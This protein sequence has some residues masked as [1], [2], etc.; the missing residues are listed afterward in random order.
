MK[1]KEAL[2]SEVISLRESKIVEGEKLCK[3]LLNTIL[4]LKGNIVFCRVRPLLSND[5]VKNDAKVA[6]F[7]T[8]TG[9]LGQGIDLTQNGQK[10]SFTLIKCSCLMPLRKM[11]M[12]RSHS[13]FRAY[14][15]DGYKVC[16]FAYGQTGSGKTHTMMDKPGLPDQK[17]LIPRSL[18]Q[19]FETRQIL[20]AQ[21]WKYDIQVQGELLLLEIYNETIRDLLAT[22]RTGSDASRAE[23]A[24][25][26]YAIKHEAN[27]NTHVSDLTVVNVR[28]SKEVSYLLERAARSSFRLVGKTQMN[29]Q[30]SRSHFVFSLR[31]MGF[32]KTLTNKCKVYLT[33]STLLVVSVYRRAGSVVMPMLFLPTA[34]QVGQGTST[35]GDHAAHEND[36]SPWEEMSKTP[37]TLR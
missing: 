1:Q 30:S 32:N 18:E 9:T 31:I 3:K 27:G 35:A 12:W 10:V 36:T 13:L 2:S 6:S 14:L 19:V 24:G 28:S 22:N 4:E 21:G 33:R 34:D 20:Q 23:N 16:I 17:G 25:K 29:E 7:L 26:K 37:E 11:F 8:S 5:G 15:M